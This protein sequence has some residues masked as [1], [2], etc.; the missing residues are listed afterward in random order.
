M[1][2]TSVIGRFDL[3]GVEEGIIMFTIIVFALLSAACAHTGKH[4]GTRPMEIK[5]VMANKDIMGGLD[6]AVDKFNSGRRNEYRVVRHSM[7]K[8]TQQVVAGKLY[9]V[10][11]RMVKSICKNVE[12]NDGKT[13]KDC[14]AKE[15]RF[16]ICI[17]S[18]WVRDWL[19]EPKKIE[20][21]MKC[22]KL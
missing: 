17:V 18:V 5:D 9:K 6:K 22:L 8:A 7:V 10:T 2:D 4:G 16:S 11:V 20:T 1:G 15:A 12:E 13:I 19:P 21:H 14:P 3:V